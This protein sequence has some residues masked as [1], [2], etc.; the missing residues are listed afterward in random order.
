M[1][2][3]FDSQSLPLSQ[4]LGDAAKG[5]LQLPDFQRGW[6]WD[7]DHIRSLL[8][9][10][11]VSYPI[12]AVMTLV[13]GNPDVKFRPRPIEGVTLGAPTEPEYLLLDGQQ[14][15]TSLY[16]ALHSEKPVPTR[17]S[18]GKSMLRHYYARH[19]GMHRP[20]HGPRGCDHQRS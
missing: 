20:I 8:A 4:L 6:V 15:A 10:I 3:K 7:D 14:R 2:K 13:T 9:S 19:A 18:R 12:G 1:E 11:S 16:L 17:D 5:K